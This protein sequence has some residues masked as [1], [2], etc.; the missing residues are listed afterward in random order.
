MLRRAGLLAYCSLV[1]A[2]SNV[3]VTTGPA[4]DE[5][6]AFDT[7]R[8][9]VDALVAAT[10]GDR[11]DDIVEILGPEGRELVYS[12]DPVTD[13]AGRELFV[14]IYDQAHAIRMDGSNRAVLVIGNKDWPFPIPVVRR[15]GAWRFDTPAGKQE[16]LDRRIGR[17]ELSAIKVCEAVVDAQRDYAERFR[18]DGGIVE[19]ARKF[20]STPGRRD[21]LYW[22]VEA[23]QPESPI[24]PLLASARAEGYG[25]E[26]DYGDREPYHGYFYKMLM[27]QG[28]NA[29]DGAYEYLVDGHMIGGFALV[30]FPAEYANSGIM[31]FIVNQ[32]G[33]IY[34]KNLGPDTAEAARAM[35]SFDPDRSWKQVK[36]TAL[37]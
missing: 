13:A 18:G 31:T 1:L 6:R 9:A 29:P 22:P 3:P 2:C 27:R 19:Y 7:P 15:K 23:G 33:I 20:I 26:E 25:V 11:A 34:Q 4:A 24:G 12:G 17:N 32:D 14:S 5:Q 8:A 30:A 16:I 21:G 37:D 35:Q 36:D 28:G 10:R